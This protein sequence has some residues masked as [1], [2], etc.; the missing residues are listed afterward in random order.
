M[1][2]ERFRQLMLKNNQEKST[3][4]VDKG[5][6]EYAKKLCKNMGLSL[7][8]AINVYIHQICYRKGIPFKIEEPDQYTVDT[9]KNIKHKIEE[10]QECKDIRKTLAQPSEICKEYRHKHHLSQRQLAKKAHVPVLKVKHLE[11]KNG[12]ADPVSIDMIAR[13]M[14]YCMHMSFGDLN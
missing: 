2:K 10:R 14:G 3:I 12:L 1:D 5:W 7:D 6:L 4:H 9:V 11:N 13:A 8:T